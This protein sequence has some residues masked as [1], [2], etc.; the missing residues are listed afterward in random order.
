MTAIK[1]VFPNPTV[2]RVI[3]QIRFP[4]LFFLES[5]IGDFQ[6]KIM[7]EFPDSSLMYRR[8]VVFA[9]LGQKAKL[10]DLNLGE[11]EKFAKKIWQFKSQKGYEMNVLNDSL[12][13]SSNLH[14]TYA[15][16]K[17]EHK[18]RDIIKLVID[19]FLKITGIPIINR[20]GLR[21]IDHCPI[22]EKKNKS[23][24]TYY[25]TSFP[26]KKFEI[27]NAENMDFTCLVVKNRYKLRYRE[28]LAQNENNK[29]IIILDIDC[30]TNEITSDKYLETT[31]DLHKLIE[32]E[33]VR[34]IKKPVIEYMRKEI[35]K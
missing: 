23:I 20:I 14:K 1:E 30:S 12:D 33:Y 22:K 29:N 9:D 17:G 15:N 8:Q 32:D 10:E 5:K 25:N 2:K 24:E 7:K 18:F 16:P 35:K 3:F 13:I 34:T 6:I 4:N 11:D 31:D 19:E 27:E 21:Y 28:T 26:L